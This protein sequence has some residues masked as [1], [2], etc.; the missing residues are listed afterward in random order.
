MESLDQ[1]K[2]VKLRRGIIVISIVL[3]LAVAA[4]FALKIEGVTLFRSF[5]SIYAAINALTALCLILALAAIKK[6]KVEQHMQWIRLA[7]VLSLVFLVMYVLYHVTSPTTYFGDTNGD[8]KIDIL[9]RAKVGYAATIYYVL[10]ISH[11][12]LSIAVVPLVLFSYLFAR[13]EQFDRHRKWVRFSYPIWLYVA[14][15]G[16]IV[17]FLISP[18]YH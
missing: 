9:E 4:L 14:I 17:Y 15:S 5:P 18:Y 13:T 12:V 10:L 8:A 6:R 2:A 16:V 1:A 11:V 3:P 7:L